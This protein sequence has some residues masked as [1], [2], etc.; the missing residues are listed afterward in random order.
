[1]LD[2]YYFK[3]SILNIIEIFLLQN[4]MHAMDVLLD[5]SFINVPLLLIFNN[6]KKISINNM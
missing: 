1:M 5:Y 6:I 4:K 3:T 2:F